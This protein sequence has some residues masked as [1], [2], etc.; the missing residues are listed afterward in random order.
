MFMSARLPTACLTVAAVLLAGWCHSGAAAKPPDLPER[1]DVICAPAPAA[2]A[3][4]PTRSVVPFSVEGVEDA[5]TKSFI[6]VM[7]LAPL[8]PPPA[9]DIRARADWN[10]GMRNLQRCMRLGCH[11]LLGLLP[12]DQEFAADGAD[13]LSE[14]WLSIAGDPRP[15]YHFF[16]DG[17]ITG[18]MVTPSPVLPCTLRPAR[19]LCPGSLYR[20]S[21]E[22]VQE[23]P[24]RAAAP[25]ARLILSTDSA[26]QSPVVVPGVPAVAPERDDFTCPY[27][28]EQAAHKQETSPCPPDAP[29]T[30]L[31]NLKKLEQAQKLYHR[32]ESYRRNGHTDEARAAFES[33]RRLCPGSRFDA[34]AG[35]R[36]QQMR[37]ATAPPKANGAAEEQD[38]AP[39]PPP[40]VKL[41]PS[42]IEKQLR[43][44]ISMSFNDVPLRRIID[45]IRSSQSLNIVLDE[46]TLAAEGVDLDH[47]LS[48]KLDQ[49]SVRSALELLARQAHFVLEIKGDAVLITTEARWRNRLTTCTY[50]VNDLVIPATARKKDDKRQTREDWLIRCITT[51]IHPMSWEQMGGHGTIEYFPL[52]QSVVVTQTPDVQDQVAELLAALR[53]LQDEE[54][55]ASESRDQAPET[56]GEQSRALD[57]EQ[58]FAALMQ[59][60]NLLM[61]QGLYEEAAMCA[62]QFPDNRVAAA[63]VQWAQ[64]HRGFRIS[65]SEP[66]TCPSVKP[67]VMRRPDLPRVDPHVAADMGKVL[68]EVKPSEQLPLSVTVEESGGTEE[69]EAAPACQKPPTLYVDPPS[70]KPAPHCDC[71]RQWQEVL[72][73]VIDKVRSVACVEVEGPMPGC[74][75]RCQIEL[76]CASFR[77]SWDRDGHGYFALGFAISTGDVPDLRAAQWAHDDAVTRWIELRGRATD[78][79]ADRGAMYGLED[80]LWP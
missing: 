47:R 10:S 16:Q 25:D 2:V 74:R 61:G 62:A 45:D 49:V 19:L 44:P 58:Q 59:R 79:P 55:K 69:Q 28:K 33:V 71:C 32:A 60:Y 53:R 75:A 14:L 70:G 9:G 64:A 3:E 67:P 20:V 23:T 48:I 12:Q 50:A 63:A 17:S 56:T 36:L 37:A 72:R 31:E 66:C 68:I 18:E 13:L 8:A 4:Q 42:T 5:G 26:A 76:G 27:L 40:P 77:G 52:G 39:P 46:P 22:Q 24:V 34:M 1:N 7:Q 21:S 78:D 80:E 54:K 11:P 30:V 6:P 35:D 57:K 73:E 38:L 41:P 51:S 43:S 29:A 65:P 15:A